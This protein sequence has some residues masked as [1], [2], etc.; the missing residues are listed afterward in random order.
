ML[1]QVS[2]L[3]GP[4]SAHFE[5]LWQCKYS[6]HWLLLPLEGLSQYMEFLADMELTQLSSVL[7]PVKPLI[8]LACERK[9]KGWLEHIVLQLSPAGGGLLGSRYQ[10]VEISATL[11]RFR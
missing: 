2:Y 8:W 3:V 7:L 4:C 1:N 6:T 10:L 5:P 9:E 11:S